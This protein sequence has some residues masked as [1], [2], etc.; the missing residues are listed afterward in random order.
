MDMVKEN[1]FYKNENYF[2]TLYRVPVS[3]RELNDLGVNEI[4]VDNQNKN[5]LDTKR[6]DDKDLAMLVFDVRIPE[7]YDSNIT[8]VKDFEPKIITDII[9][10]TDNEWVYADEI[11]F[12]GNAK[13]FNKDREL[14][15]VGKFDFG[16]AMVEDL[17]KTKDRLISQLPDFEEI[18]NSRRYPDDEYDLKDNSWDRER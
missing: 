3:I 9:V 17:D 6:I 1:T 12:D 11:C 14:D 13:A 15:L 16:P 2:S 4:T 7:N 8:D 5:P 10:K 18:M